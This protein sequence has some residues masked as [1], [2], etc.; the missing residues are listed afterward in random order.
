MVRRIFTALLVLS[1]GTLSSCYRNTTVLCQQENIQLR[2]NGF[3]V[4]QLDTVI[5]QRF[6]KGSGFGAL[7][8][9][10]HLTADSTTF[11][12]DRDTLVPLSS[13]GYG[14][15]AP[16]NDYVIHVPA[17]GSEYRVSDIDLE[18]HASETY[19]EAYGVTYDRDPCINHIVSFRLDS[20]TTFTARAVYQ[21]AYVVFV[22]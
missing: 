8:G 13:L 14:V 9:T 7:A 2:Y 10:I 6:E 20:A 4:T 22:R 11:S 15:L 17:T 16:G 21:D 19:R 1:L 12:N 5:V 18:G 3:E